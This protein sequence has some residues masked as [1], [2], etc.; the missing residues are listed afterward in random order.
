MYTKSY[1]SNRNRLVLPT[2][3]SN[4]LTPKFRKGLGLGLVK[5]DTILKI[6]ESRLNGNCLY[7]SAYRSPVILL[8]IKKK[9]VSI[10]LKLLLFIFYLLV[11]CFVIA[12][13]IPIFHLLH[14]NNAVRRRTLQGLFN[15]RK[16]IFKS[17]VIN[18]RT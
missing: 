13:K 16:S 17:T 10:C 14:R 4:E 3:S 2:I 6:F 9:Q 7:V 18:I 11:T 5:V 15:S 12:H 8:Q 1:Y